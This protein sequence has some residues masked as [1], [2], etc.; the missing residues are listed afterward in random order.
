MRDDVLVI[1]GVGGMGM[2][3][4]RRCG[5]GARVLLADVNGVALDAAATTLAA[6]GYDVTTQTTD[7]ADAT[8]VAALADA[9]RSLGSVRSVV[10]TSGVSPVQAPAELVVAVDLVGVAHVLASFATV[11]AHG[12]AAVV[13][14][15]MAGHLGPPLTPED[16]AAVAR[17]SVTEL[18]SLPCVQQAAA[19]DPG[20]A[21]TFAKRACA[22]LVQAASVTWGH[23]GARVNT[24]SPG[25][26][27]TPMGHA[28]LA[29]PSGELM[30]MMVESSGT[31][32]L[33]S[34]D[35]IA[36]ATEFLLSR[37]ASFI[38]GTDLLVDGGAVAAVRSGQLGVQRVHR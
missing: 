36:A 38:T 3:V 7:V 29:G 25:V 4:A 9:A 22:V 24:I 12:G 10:H 33:G 11:M 35:D 21:Y 5:S 23:R 32:R 26:I 19:G 15:S 17:A 1:T 28:E 31:G 14:A 34:P 6:D 20:L 27:A 37:R 18:P 30:R 13:I 8:S 16:E 2:A